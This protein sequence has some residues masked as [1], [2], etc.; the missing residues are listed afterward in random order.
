MSIEP[1]RELSACGGLA[2]YARS[3]V[4]QR[5]RTNW[6]ARAGR[7]DDGAHPRSSVVKLDSDRWTRS[8]SPQRR[9]SERCWP[10]ASGLLSAARGGELT[11]HCCNR[12]RS[13]CKSVIAD[14]RG[15]QRP[16]IRGRSVNDQPL[17]RIRESVLPGGPLRSQSR[18]EYGAAD[19]ADIRSPTAVSFCR[20]TRFESV[21]GSGQIRRALT[22]QADQFGHLLAAPAADRD[23]CAVPQDQH[24]FPRPCRPDL[25]HAVEPNDRRPVHAHETVGVQTL[26]ERGERLANR[27]AAGRARGPPRSSPRPGSSRSRRRRAPAHQSSSGQ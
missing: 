2:R 13:A 14:A 6:R 5:V 7:G 15:A 4:G 18:K 26:L 8:I 20:T 9:V 27:D 11:V 21:V 1:M 3:D 17:P 22:R 19:R 23:T 12:D 24:R 16:R 10:M 25:A